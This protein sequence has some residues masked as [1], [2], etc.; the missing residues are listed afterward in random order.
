MTKIKSLIHRSSFGTREFHRSVKSVP[1]K[2]VA[3]LIRQGRSITSS[4]WA[5]GHPGD[6][7]PLERHFVKAAKTGASKQLAA[8]RRSNSGFRAVTASLIILV[9]AVVLLAD[10][11]F[12][13]H[14][15][16]EASEATARPTTHT[17]SLVIAATAS[18][19]E[20]RL[21]VP[22]AVHQELLQAA[23]KSQK[24]D[25]AT[26]A[27]VVAGQPTQ[28]FDLTPMRGRQVEHNTTLRKRKAEAIVESFE[29]LITDSVAGVA[30]LDLLGV[31]DRAGREDHHAR[32][33]ALSSGVS[34]VPPL[35]LREFGWPDGEQSV[36]AVLKSRNELPQYLAGR[37]IR[38]YDLADT[39]GRQPRLTI[40]LRKGIIHAYLDICR[41]AGGV[42]ESEDDAA[43]NLRALAT[44][45]VPVVPLPKV[46]SV[47]RNS[48]CEQTLRVPSVLLFAPNSAA[49]DDGAD[50]AL[51]PIVDEVVNG[52]GRSVITEI[53]GHTADV[54]A[55]DGLKLSQ[56]RA[57]AVARRLEQ[58]G[59]PATLIKRVV[60]R[61]ESRPV[62]G[63]RKPDGSI[64]P[65]EARN[66][67][68]EI[69]MRSVNC[70]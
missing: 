26:V 18:R 17:A 35:D 58:L 15:S 55:G 34:T 64:S 52:R 32:I 22:S 61:G 44:Q 46:I 13:G 24:A 5:A 59:V 70:P 38:F 56:S 48:R 14:T 67:R 4:E 43:S 69:S 41:S 39:A 45:P 11:L 8:A 20:W 10:L 47:P 7:A 27:L 53:S 28:R 36:A 6:V 50:A 21:Q 2:Q 54:D 68:V 57:R 62:A 19:A 23:L 29:R 42:C 9:I 65:S 37:D 51:R 1:R 66:R 16:L 60:G 25:G 30:G 12:R 33:V 31:L 49:L 40:P 3:S 63:S